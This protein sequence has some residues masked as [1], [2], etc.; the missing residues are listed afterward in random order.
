MVNPSVTAPVLTRTTPLLGNT[1]VAKVIGPAG[2]SF[3]VPGGLHVVVPPLALDRTIIM[4][5]T[6]LKGD[7]VGYVFGP[8]GTVFNVPLILTQDLRGT[9]GEGM[10]GISTT[11]V[12]YFTD[13]TK[14][15]LVSHTA[16]I[17]EFLP[18]SFSVSLT[19]KSLTYTVKHFSG[20]VIVTGRAP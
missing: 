9:S 8:H 10:T 14:L 12:G 16:S 18:A 4:S 2:G 11:E 19:G 6:A 5:V 15:N 20:Y 13:P 1:S 3:T 7:I 17:S